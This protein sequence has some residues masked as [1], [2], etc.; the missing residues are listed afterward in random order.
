[1]GM[2]MNMGMLARV[3]RSLRQL[4]FEE[5]FNSSSVRISSIPCGA[6]AGMC[7]SPL[8]PGRATHCRA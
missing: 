7:L 8:A 5:W 6:A 3:Y 2:F 1:M 4:M